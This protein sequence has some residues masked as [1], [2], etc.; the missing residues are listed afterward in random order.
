VAVHTFEKAI[1]RQAQS[2]ENDRAHRLGEHAPAEQHFVAEDTGRR[3]S[4]VIAHDRPR[5]DIEKV[6]RPQGEAQIP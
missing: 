3:S 6:E 5:R 2:D 4:S 1:E